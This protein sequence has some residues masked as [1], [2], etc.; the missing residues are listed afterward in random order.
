MKVFINYRR[1]DSEAYARLLRDRLADVYGA[2]SV[3]L[4]VVDLMPGLSWLEQIKASSSSCGAFLA[5]IGPRWMSTMTDR[6][7]RRF[8]DAPQDVVRR[9]IEFA[10]SRGSQVQVIPLLVGG[11]QMP[12]GDGLVRSIRPLTSLQAVELRH[13]Q[14]DSDLAHLIETLNRIEGRVESDAGGSAGPEPVEEHPPAAARPTAAAAEPATSPQGTTPMPDQGHFAT[15][16]RYLLDD[17][18]LVPVLGPDVNFAQSGHMASNGSD[19]FPN[20]QELAIGLSHRFG[21]EPVTD[22]LAKVAQQVFLTCGSP[23][24][25]RGLK[26]LLS[27]DAEP[28]VV[29]RFLAE[30]PRRLEEL[31]LPRRRQLI[32]TT[33]YDDALERAFDDANEPY[34][35]A[36]YMASG[37]DRGRFVHFPVDADPEVITLPNRYGKLPIDEYGEVQRSLIVK[38]HGAVDGSSGGYRWKD[39]YVI[40]EDQYI[41]Y[42]SH[43]PVERLVPIQILDKLT[44]AH[45]LFLGYSMHDWNLRVFLKRIWGGAPIPAKSWAVERDPES[46]ESDFWRHSGVDLIAAPLADYVQQLAEQMRLQSGTAD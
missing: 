4:D 20:A 8:D 41:E 14:F 37:I 28:S 9:E 19:T 31:G 17:D 32:V 23:D 26:R 22:D 33:N 10:L 46:M 12:S 36:V 13:A 27:R 30:F 5:L 40:T 42:L 45:C 3:F 21:I 24:L 11:A 39:N 16:L 7:Q 1:E 6:A 18:G 44:S 35:V 34:D 43:S 15:V 2:E 25:Y 29:H 38:V